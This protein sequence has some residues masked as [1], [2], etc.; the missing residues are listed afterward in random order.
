MIKVVLPGSEYW[1]RLGLMKG[2]G[3]DANS[4][5]T[6][7]LEVVYLNPTHT[8]PVLK[9]RYF[10]PIRMTTLLMSFLILYMF[11][12]FFNNFIIRRFKKVFIQKEKLFCFVYPRSIFSIH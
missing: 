1:S 7:N 3:V 5:V 6:P 11:V 10:Y 9:V 8:F 4:S 2:L 12:N